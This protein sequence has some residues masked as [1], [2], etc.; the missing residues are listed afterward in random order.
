MADIRE[1]EGAG[2]GGRGGDDTWLAVY[3]VRRS[4][5]YNR[6]L[7]GGNLFFLRE[8]SSNSLSYGD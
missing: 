7:Q 5:F 6:L 2:G 3:R 4:F 1:G 8:V